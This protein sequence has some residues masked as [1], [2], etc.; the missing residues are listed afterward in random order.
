MIRVVPVL[1][2]L[3][4]QDEIGRA[5]HHPGGID[6]RRLHRRA[7]G[8]ISVKR[9]FASVSAQHLHGATRFGLGGQLG[10]KRGRQ[11]IRSGQVQSIEQ[12]GEPA[13]LRDLLDP[14]TCNLRVEH[15]AQPLRS[16]VIDA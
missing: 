16:H 10:D 11:T 3:K 15:G 5:V 14:H 8:D 4:Q 9:E 13:V 12:R 6:V 2:I 1:E 7:A